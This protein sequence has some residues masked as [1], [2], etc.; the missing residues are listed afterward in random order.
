MIIRSVSLF[1]LIQFVVFIVF[2]GS[3]DAQSCVWTLEDAQALVATQNYNVTS[4]DA[5]I[6][7]SE[8]LET[9][10]MA[11]LL[12]SANVT[13]VYTLHDE[14]ITFEMGNPYAPLAPYLDSVYANDPA[15]SSNPEVAPPSA[16]TGSSSEPGIIQHRH[17]YR[18]IGTLSQ[19]I[20]NGQALPAL[21]LA[22]QTMTSVSQQRETVIFQL[23]TAVQ[24]L[25]FEALLARRRQEAA[26]QNV[27]LLRVAYERA[28]IAFEEQVGLEFEANRAR[29]ALASAERDA[30]N[31]ELGYSLVLE[32]LRLLVNENSTCDVVD[33]PVLSGSSSSN[34]EER[35]DML[36]LQNTIR[37]S[38][39][40]LSVR[41]G[42]RLPTVLAQFQTTGSRASEFGGDGVSWLVQLTASWDF[43]TAGLVQSEIES[44]SYDIEIARID[45]EN[46]LAQAQSEITQ[47]Q[48]M[49]QTQQLQLQSAQENMELAEENL[50][51]TEIAYEE[52]VSSTLD[53]ETSR[54]QLY[55]TRL[56][57]LESETYLQASYYRLQ[58]LTE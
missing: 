47:L 9:R 53:V 38:E 10:A 50:A 40:I 45:Y 57:V 37:S 21:R 14:E 36:S 4:I 43:F 25:Y 44:A 54:T 41:E 55:L 17:D 42:A 8:L 22:R 23:E 31:A 18:V 12:P 51:L 2:S 3:S 39:R 28:T 29:V 24:A 20:F 15:L 13:A 16:L 7:Q 34:L 30:A 19:V 11:T 46:Q 27:A 48:Q 58:H 5:V 49:I 26:E 1:A 33:P 6:E 56:A 32:S 52:N 35:A